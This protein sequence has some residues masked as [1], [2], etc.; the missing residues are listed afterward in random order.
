MEDASLFIAEVL[1]LLYRWQVDGWVRG[2]VAARSRAS[3]VLHM[4][5]Y[6]RTSALV[7]AVVAQ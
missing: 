1:L 4:V 6:C 7:S 5:L 2:T 3:G